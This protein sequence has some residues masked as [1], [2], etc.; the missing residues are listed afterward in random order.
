[1]DKIEVNGM[2]LEDCRSYIG[3][4][5]KDIKKLLEERFWACGTVAKIKALSDDNTVLNN[6]V[7]EK[8]LEEIAKTSDDRFATMNIEVFKK[9]MEMSRNWQ[10]Q[11]IGNINV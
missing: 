1:M 2:T 6:T 4:I 11:V 7:E 5:D 3:N 8:K 9:I 10:Y